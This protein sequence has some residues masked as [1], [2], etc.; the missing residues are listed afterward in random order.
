MAKR[1]QKHAFRDF[2]GTSFKHKKALETDYK[3]GF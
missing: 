2:A 3:N 1:K